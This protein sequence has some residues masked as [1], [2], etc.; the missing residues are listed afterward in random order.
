MVTPVTPGSPPKLR[1][2][3]RGGYGWADDDGR[4]GQKQVGKWRKR[5]GGAKKGLEQG[6]R[7]REYEREGVRG[8]FSNNNEAALIDSAA[9]RE[10]A[11]RGQLMLM[12]LES[13]L[14]L[15]FNKV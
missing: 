14:V 4:P 13:I 9:M 8:G 2:R 10:C 7:E 15:L 3:D 1:A 6:E 12:E 11:R 5:K